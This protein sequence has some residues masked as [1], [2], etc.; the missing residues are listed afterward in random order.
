MTKPGAPTPGASVTPL[1]METRETLGWLESMCMTYP[2]LKPAAS[3]AIKVIRKADAAAGWRGI[4]SAPR[5]GTVI[6]YYN[7]QHKIPS[8]CNHLDEDERM[9]ACWWDDSLTE[10]VHPRWWRPWAAPTL[11]APPTAN[12]EDGAAVPEPF[13]EKFPNEPPWRD[14]ERS[15]MVG[16]TKVYRSYEDYIDD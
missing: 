13:H 3:R 2:H 8:L 1:E 11:P 12:V 9:H 14:G 10:E 4:E 5:D 7:A 15:R 6:E 16:N